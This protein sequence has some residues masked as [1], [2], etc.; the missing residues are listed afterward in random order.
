M[1]IRLKDIQRRHKSLLD[2]VH[3]AKDTIAEVLLTHRLP[4]MFDGVEFGTV[5]RKKNETDVVRY[6][7]FVFSRLVSGSSIQ[8]E[9]EQFV[10][11]SPGKLFQE[12]LMHC[13]MHAWEN[14]R[15]H[16]SIERTESGK[17]ICVLADRLLRHIR[18]HM[19]RRPAV[20]RT[21]DASE[22]CLVLKENTERESF[23][24]SFE[25]RPF[26]DQGEKTL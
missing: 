10:R 21:G 1:L 19:L 25:L 11:V 20:C 9:T 5:G 26:Q 22:S 6:L 7:Q 8:D 17:R 3:T 15:I 24:L 16:G 4:Q 12:T 14:E 13:R 23:D 2:A 18:P